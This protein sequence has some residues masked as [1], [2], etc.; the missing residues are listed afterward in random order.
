MVTLAIDEL[1]AR[2]GL[3]GLDLIKLDVEGA[4]LAT[5]RGAER[6]L[7]AFRPKLAISVTPGPV[8]RISW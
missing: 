4:E 8:R 7:R 5:L 1:I 2:R 6:S 3:E